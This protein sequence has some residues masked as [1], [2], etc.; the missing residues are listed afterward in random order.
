MD[1]AVFLIPYSPFLPLYMSV[2]LNSEEEQKMAAMAQRGTQLFAFT[3]EG[4]EVVGDG[5]DKKV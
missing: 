2:I 5:G 4:A 3:Y 1:V